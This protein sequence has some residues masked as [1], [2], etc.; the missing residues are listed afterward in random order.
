MAAAGHFIFELFKIAIL[1][2]I[3]SVLL[4]ILH[5]IFLTAKGINPVFGKQTFNRL[6]KIVYASLFVFSFTYYG[7]HGLGD[8]DNIPLGYGETMEAGD[9]LPYFCPKGKNQVAVKNYLVRGDKLCATTYYGVMVYNLNTKQLKDFNSDEQ[10][11]AYAENHDLPPTGQM[12]GFEQQYN[13]YWSGWRFW[14]LP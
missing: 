8:A 2:F 3:Y 13:E 4:G 12:L 1:S 6:F 14:V 5:L 7:N 9:L 10:Y 11:N